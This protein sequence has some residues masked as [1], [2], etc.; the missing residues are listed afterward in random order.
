MKGQHHTGP[1][2]LT[3]ANGVAKGSINDVVVAERTRQDT[4]HGFGVCFGPV[5]ETF[6]KN[7]SGKVGA[8]STPR[9]KTKRDRSAQMHSA[10]SYAPP[11]VKHKNFPGEAA[12]NV[13]RSYRDLERVLWSM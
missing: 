2:R 12:Q 7:H 11:A 8:A 9:K 10:Q 3:C 4:V 1:I 13:L 5:E 6:W